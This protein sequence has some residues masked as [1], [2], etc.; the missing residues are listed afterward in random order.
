MNAARALLIAAAERLAAAGVDSARVDARVLFAHVLGVS[1]SELLMNSTD[2][3][4][5]LS[6]DVL[7]RFDAAIARRARREPVAYIT[8]RKDFWNLTF[9]VG[10]GALIPRPE[11]ELMIELAQ[12]RFRDHDAVLNALDLGTGSGCILLTFLSIYPKAQGLGIDISDEALSW[13]RRNARK[14]G[15]ELRTMFR[16]NRWAEG[17]T[18]SFDVIFANP[19]YIDDTDMAQLAPEV[20]GHEP[21]GALHGGADGLDAYRELAPQIAARLTPGGFALVEVGLGQAAAVESLFVA[22]GLDARQTARD[23]AGIPRNLVFQRPA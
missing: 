12:H 20:G 15:V 13:A 1:S 14:F 5:R 21:H 19:P 23:L 18:G 3:D 7:E 6:A 2:V 17:I 8:G 9:D 10:P 16:K 4:R 22:H 11:T